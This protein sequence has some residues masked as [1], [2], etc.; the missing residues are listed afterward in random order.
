M[1]PSILINKS[2]RFNIF[3]DEIFD[4]SFIHAGLEDQYFM[5]VAMREWEKYT[6]VRFKERITEENFTRFQNG[7]GYV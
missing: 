7:F 3:L 6:C 1:S 4:I 2:T 5:K